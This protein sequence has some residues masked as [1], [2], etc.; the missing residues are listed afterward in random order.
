MSVYE[1]KSPSF[2]FSIIVRHGDLRIYFSKP[3]LGRIQTR[4]LLGG[5]STWPKLVIVQKVGQAVT[6]SCAVAFIIT[7]SLLVA[8]NG[9][10]HIRSCHHIGLHFTLQEQV[11]Q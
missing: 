1:L 4:R 9:H 11:L 3:L 10:S 6:S 7:H 2:G 8:W 5:D